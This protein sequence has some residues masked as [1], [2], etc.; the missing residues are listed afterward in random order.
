MNR[1]GLLAVI[2][3]GSIFCGNAQTYAASFTDIN[4]VPWEGAKTYINSVADL[5]L[6]VGDYDSRNNLVF[7]SRDGVTYCETMQLVYSLMQRSGSGT[8][9]NAILSKWTSVMNGYKIPS[10]V[11]PAVAYGL[12]NNII[13]ISDIPGFVTS[14]GSATVN[15]TR[16]DVAIMFGRSLEKYGTLNSSASLSF[17]DKSAVSAIAVPYIDLLVK[18][19]VVNGD[20]NNNFNPRNTINRAEMA[21]IVSKSY[22][23]VQNANKKPAVET[24]SISGKVK[25]VQ[26]V[27]SGVVLTVND[28]SKDH[29][30]S[31][32]DTTPVLDGNTRVLM[33]S[34]REGYT[35]SVSYKG[36]DI[37]SILITTKTTGSS[38]LTNT[39][40][41]TV[42]GLYNSVSSS[43]IKIDSGS[44]SKT[45]DFVGGSYD[46]VKFYINSK[47]TTYRDFR[48]DAIK[49]R[50]IKL[51]L[52]GNGRV[53][54]ARVSGTVSGD[55]VSISESNIKIKVAGK[56]TTYYFD[57]KDSDNAD[58]YIDGS[59]STYSKF[60][61]KAE[62][63]YTVTLT[64]DDKNDYVEKA[65][66]ITKNTDGDT[67][68]GEFSSITARYIRIKS[69]SGRTTDYYFDDEDS[70]NVKFYY[71]GTSRSYDYI[72]SNA[73]SGDDVKL[74]LDRN[75]EVTKVWVEDDDSDSDDTVKGEFY[76]IYSRYIRIKTNGEKTRDYDF[77][78]NSNN[79]VKFYYEDKLKDY[80]Y[81]RKYVDD[82]EDVKLELNSDGEVTKVWI[83]GDGDDDD[84]DTVRGTFSS[85]SSRY[86]RVKTSSGKSK[87]YYFDDEDNENV[88]FY[89]DDKSRDYDYIKRNAESG[90]DVRLDLNRS[91][92]VTKVRISSD[93]YDDDDD[94]DDDKISGEF[95]SMTK[96]RITI[97]KRNG[98][99]EEY[100]FEDR[101][102]E[103][104]KFYF[105]DRSRDY[106][107]VSDNV[108]KGD[109]VDIELKNGEVVKVWIES[110]SDNDDDY[111]DDSGKIKKATASEIRIGNR[112]Y[113]FDGDSD[114][115]KI[116]IKDGKND[117][118]TDYDDLIAA[119]EEDDK[120]IEVTADI[121]KH[122]EITKLTG[123]VETAEGTLTRLEEDSVRIEFDSGNRSDYVYSK[124]NV[125]FSVS[126]GYN[127]SY[128]GLKKAYESN[129]IESV[130]VTLTFSK[131]GRVLKIEAEP[132]EK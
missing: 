62:T 75:G 47:S 69:S 111:D 106:D 76:A 65:D 95:V 89:Y 29:V 110:D 93:D 42:S 85:I 43:S 6:M 33:S 130:D 112:T 99:E 118:I 90:D 129:K 102:E 127:D 120:V 117:S 56:S 126:G 88:K 121:N 123:Y 108:R 96:R 30:F 132:N 57:D 8:V 7:R 41:S 12:E 27:G 66:L 72:R 32:T 78:G 19:G 87:E 63:K 67:V 74:E 16:Q 52:D 98:R 115:I 38:S 14:S 28:G 131:S 31:G 54:E 20:A 80:D 48:D 68:R 26:I 86:I 83:S 100:D 17:N 21:V 91:G 25:S 58:F 40:K 79:N 59:K 97:E 34:I 124:D 104:V 44:S 5:G 4:N 2:M 36:Q 94:D 103:N 101:D 3:A 122:K 53:T 10:W 45:Y 55:F 61:N 64:V 119:V 51:T 9:S 60:K 15:A 39:S 128:S 81:I 107:Y 70:D 113:S 109:S 24:G 11:Q 18:L 82:G 23:V 105:E 114:D 1:K 37:M 49:G 50:D 77:E 84:D 116:D 35:V 22:D 73:E 46:D 13:T 92:E 125:E 71:K